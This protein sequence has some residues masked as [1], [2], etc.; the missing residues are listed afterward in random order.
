MTDKELLEMLIAMMRINVT[1]TNLLFEKNVIERQEV[2]N[3]MNGLIEIESSEPKRIIFRRYLEALE[4]KNLYGDI[5]T[6]N[7]T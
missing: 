6:T 2:I 3:I 1:I 4:E 7:P 5:Q